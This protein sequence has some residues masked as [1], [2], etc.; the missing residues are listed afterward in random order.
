MCH[1]PL[2]L[3]PGPA[4]L[5]HDRQ[6]ALVDSGGATLRLKR[7]PRLASIAASI[8]LQRRLLVVEAAGQ[9]PL[10]IALPADGPPGGSSDA[11]SSSDSSSGGDAPVGGSSA[12]GDDG[13][14]GTAGGGLQA[15]K[16]CAR[17][18]CVEHAASARGATLRWRPGLVACWACP[19]AWCSKRGR[20]AA[21]RRG[22][23]R[24]LVA[25]AAAAAAAAPAAA[26]AAAAAPLLLLALAAPAASPMRGSCWLWVPPAWQ[27]LRSAAAA[28]SRRPCLLSA[29]GVWGWGVGVV[30]V[31]V[32]GGVGG[33]VGW[34][35]GG[36][37]GIEGAT[38]Q[39]CKRLDGG[40]GRLAWP[41]Y[42]AA[43]RPGAA[44]ARKHVRNVALLCLGPIS[45]LRPSRQALC[46]PGPTEAWPAPAVFCRPNLV[47]GGTASLFRR[48]LDPAVLQRRCAAPQQQQRRQRVS[49]HI[50]GG[51]RSRRAVAAAA[52]GGSR[53]VHT[54]RHDLRR[55]AD[56]LV[57]PACV[58]ALTGP[59]HHRSP[60][61]RASCHPAWPPACPQP[62]CRVNTRRLLC[63]AQ[64][65]VHA[66]PPKHAPAAPPFP[67][68][69]PSRTGPEPLLTLAGYR[70]SRGR[71]TFGVLLN[72]RQRGTQAARHPAAAG[73][74][75]GRQQAGLAAQPLAA[76]EAN[77]PQGERAVASGPPAAWLSVGMAVRPQQA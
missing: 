55:P 72:R 74:A 6:W 20:R 64:R 69:P 4:G 66:P 77:Q 23:C 61:L 47:I 17:S 24:V 12:E 49:Q 42:F 13:A 40:G 71:I 48:R 60:C 52:A 7:H 27:T 33:G 11:S 16:V 15:I 38:K 14:G 2:P 50:G 51:G 70:R 73:A 29:S 37:G 44:H 56:W 25:A 46:Q 54:V 58:P 63:Q 22:C 67:P 65:C 53:P 3:P 30:V 41:G 36:G 18:A 19:A 5:L 45:A 57:S 9:K 28:R 68:P 34:G 31:V 8:D 35:G 75:V 10:E 21:R 43:T 62:A 76:G 26:P 32:W 59:V 39:E 1:S